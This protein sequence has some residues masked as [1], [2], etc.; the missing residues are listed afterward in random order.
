VDLGPLERE[1]KI[2]AWDDKRI[3][4][5]M[6]WLKEIES[7]LAP[8][9]VSVLLVSADFLASEFVGLL[10]SSEVPT[11]RHSLILCR[12]RFLNLCL[13]LNHLKRCPLAPRQEEGTETRFSS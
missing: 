11:P 5:G 4:P 10:Q 6:D 13:I 3:K 2:E 12:E 7:T 9:R 8:A 1:G